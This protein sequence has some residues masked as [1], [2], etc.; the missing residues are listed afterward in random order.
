MPGINKKPQIFLILKPLPQG[1]LS[2]YQRLIVEFLLPLNKIQ[3]INLLTIDLFFDD[4]IENVDLMNDYVF[5]DKDFAYNNLDVV[6][7]FQHGVVMLENETVYF[8]KINKLNP[9][10]ENLALNHNF[11]ILYLK[12]ETQENTND[13]Y[14]IIVDNSN[15][16]FNYEKLVSLI[17]KNN[18][19]H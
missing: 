7:S 9:V 1:K 11:K 4:R 3:K 13:E 16:L 10:N 8:R 5:I 14:R 12:P 2:D 19:Q 6:K 18:V 17:T 15:Y